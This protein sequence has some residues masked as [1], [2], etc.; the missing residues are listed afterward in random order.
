MSDRKL[1]YTILFFFLLILIAGMGFV[2]QALFIPGETRIIAFSEIGNLRLEDGVRIRGIV[3]GTV[4]KIDRTHE[5]VFVSIQ[6]SRPVKIHRGY[7]VVNVDQGVMGDRILRISCGDSATPLIPA[8]DTLAGTFYPGVSEAMSYA[9]LL[10]DV[11]DTLV[12]YSDQ[13]LHGTSARKSLVVQVMGIISAADSLSRVFLYATRDF[14]AGLSH[15]LDSI[16]AL[17][18]KTAHFSSSVAATT[19]EYFDNLSIMV[20]RLSGL[21]TTLDTTVSALHTMASGLQKPDNILWGRDADNVRKKLV[22]LQEI[23]V[24]IQKRM[25]QFKTYIGLF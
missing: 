23:I 25:L 12:F 6:C 13:M 19:P 8:Q 7:S 3:L 18:N 17:V 21:V 24:T 2:F 9:Y 15:Q 16:D 10:R 5:K 22:E 14:N 4:K 11:V 20:G 1:G